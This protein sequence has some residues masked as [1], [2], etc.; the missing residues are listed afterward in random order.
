MSPSA[1]SS[2]SGSSSGSGGSSALDADRKDEK[3]RQ[4]VLQDPFNLFLA[5]GLAHRTEP[6]LD[7]EWSGAFMPLRFVKERKVKA[8]K[9]PLQSGALWSLYLYGPHDVLLAFCLHEDC[10]R[11]RQEKRPMQGSASA[12]TTRAPPPANRTL[13]M[14]N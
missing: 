12:R 8:E 10:V 2:S 11:D 7:P 1:L 9:K 13:R 6:L 5:A 3:D 14:V 4:H